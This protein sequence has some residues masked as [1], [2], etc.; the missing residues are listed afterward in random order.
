MHVSVME[1]FIENIDCA[2]FEGKRVLEIGSR[3]VNGSVR[4]L[5]ERFCKPREYI[6]IDIEPG[7]Y[8]DIVLP[9]E[10]VVNFFGPEAFDVVVSTETLEHVFDWRIVIDNMKKVLKYGGFL[11]ITTRSYGFPYHAYPYDFWRFEVADMIRIFKDFRVI[12]LIR[13]W[14]APGVFLKAMKLRTGKS[15]DL[16][17]I[18]LYNIVLGGRTKKPVKL[19]DI[20]LARRLI[21]Q[22][23]SSRF[24]RFMP[25]PSSRYCI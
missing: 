2:E 8:V 21:L 12:R 25:L 23:C 15:V 24:K 13:D 9:A 11:Y 22:F 18:A 20:P 10:E 19:S 5:I 6:G 7:R 14:E 16:N 3:Y 1:F 4:P 17:S